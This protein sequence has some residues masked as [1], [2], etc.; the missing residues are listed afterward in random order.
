MIFVSKSSM[1]VQA[2]NMEI[3]AT[4]SIQDIA[5]AIVPCAA[6]EPSRTRRFLEFSANG[7]MPVLPA[8]CVRMS[9]LT[10]A[11]HEVHDFQ[12]ISLL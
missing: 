12:V 9:V 1:G 4:V 6:A 10:S 8:I 7:P 5:A 2:V 3:G 11:A